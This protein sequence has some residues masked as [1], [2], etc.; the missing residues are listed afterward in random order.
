MEDIL[1]EVLFQTNV[2]TSCLEVACRQ[3]PCEDPNAG[4]PAFRDKPLDRLRAAPTGQRPPQYQQQSVAPRGVPQQRAPA[5][6]AQAVR[7]TPQQNIVVGGQEPLSSHALAQ[8]SPQEQK[9]MLGERIYTLIDKMYN[10]RNDAGKITGMMLEMD[11]AELIMM[12]QDDE[13]FRQKVGEAANVLQQAQQN[14][15]PK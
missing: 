5:G 1:S 8:A 6:Y 14:Q 7:P 2:E 11:N 9:Q 15:I 3:P 13:L 10:G 4:R 12:L